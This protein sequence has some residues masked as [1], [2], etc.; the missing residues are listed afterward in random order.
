MKN[1]GKGLAV[2]ILLIFEILLSVVLTVVALN[3]HH[4]YDQRIFV[5]YLIGC[6][7]AYTITAFSLFFY[8]RNKN[9]F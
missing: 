7:I 6:G 3:F 4:D 9:V 5:K 1:S 2:K 8:L